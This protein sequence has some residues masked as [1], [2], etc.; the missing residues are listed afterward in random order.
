MSEQ[1]PGVVIYAAKST[2][3]THGSIP[4]QIED[5]RALAER[6]GWVIVGEYQDEAKSAFHGNRGEQLVA[7]RDHAGRVGGTIVV[8]HSDRLARGDGVR[9]DHLVEL[10]LWARKNG[11]RWAS[12]QD[13]QTFDAM[14]LVYAALM[15]DRNHDDS[16]RKSAAVVSGLKRRANKGK[17]V[18]AMPLG[19]IVEKV[20][21]EDEVITKRVIDPVTREIIERIFEKVEAGD[22][23]GDVARALNAEG[24]TGRRGKPWTS[25]TVRTIVHNAAYAG[26]KGY[27]QLIEPERWQRIQDGLHRLDPAAA[28]RRK[29]GRKP[30]DSSYW[31][32]GTVFCLACEAAL[33]TRR[34]AAGRMYVCSNRRTGT[35]LCHAAPIPADLI[36]SHVLDHLEAFVGDTKAWLTQQAEQRDDGRQ[37]LLRAAQ[38]LCDDRDRVEQR[39]E[40]LLDDY[41]AL[42]DDYPGARLLLDRATSLDSERV[43]LTVKIEDTEAMAA[44]WENAGDSDLADAVDLVRALEHADTAQALNAALGRALAGIYARVSDGKLRAEFELAALLPD[45]RQGVHL[46]QHAKLT[47]LDSRRV[48]LD[49]GET[50]SFTFV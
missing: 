6:A 14:G 48:T 20:V 44:E 11:V 27:P 50:R 13:P 25:R 38:R 29:G 1:R 37:Q 8:Q 31:L 35:G 10:V 28:Q 30:V 23:F 5:C 34:Q 9:S 19:Y 46:F 16:A 39:R 24:V 45:H 49:E 3:D 18:G 17:P 12:V 43:A 21:V 22:T 32:R 4:T 41:E 47:G 36:E 2:E 26:Q 7:A 15:G 42:P 40:R 33:Y